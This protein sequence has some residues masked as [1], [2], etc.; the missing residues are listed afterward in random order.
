MQSTVLWK[1][2]FSFLRHSSDDGHRMLRLECAIQGSALTEV[3][4]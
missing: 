1:K 3:Q 4:V 2:P